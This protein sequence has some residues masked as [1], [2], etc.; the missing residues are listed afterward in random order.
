MTKTENFIN[1]A[2]NIHKNKDGSP[3]YQYQKVIYIKSAKK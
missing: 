2:K 1:R 3:K